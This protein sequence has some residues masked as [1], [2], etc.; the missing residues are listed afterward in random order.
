MGTLAFLSPRRWRRLGWF[1][2][3][4]LAEVAHSYYVYQSMEGAPLPDTLERL[5]NARRKVTKDPLDPLELV[6]VV[7][8]FLHPIYGTSR[9]LPRAMILF[10]MLCRRGFDATV[11]YGVSTGREELDGHAW[12]LLSG[13]PLGESEDP[14]AKYVETYRYPM[15]GGRRTIS[16]G[17]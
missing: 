10:C 5:S 15:S 4:I 8:W 9:C 6:R 7:D 1:G 16:N 17:L 11:V 2:L 13:E 12:V 14:R 3:P